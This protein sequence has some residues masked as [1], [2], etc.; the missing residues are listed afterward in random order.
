LTKGEIDS[1]KLGDFKFENSGDDVYV[2]QNGI[3]RF[4]GKWKKR[5]IG[6]LGI[7]PIE[8]METIEKNGELYQ[9][10]K[11]LRVNRL[12]TCILNN[13]LSEIGKFSTV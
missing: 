8:H 5:G 1:E 3:Y 9:V 2:L 7:K 6:K 12:R 10:F 13:S 11:L 4:N